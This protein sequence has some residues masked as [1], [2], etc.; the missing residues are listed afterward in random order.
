MKPAVD[1]RERGSGASH[2]DRAFR[3]YD[4]RTDLLD[5]S[6][7]EKQRWFDALVESTYLPVLG[8][9]ESCRVLDVGCNRGYLLRALQN[10]GFE[11]LTGVDLAPRDLDEARKTTGLDT[12]YCEDAVD[13]L[14]RHR[15]EFDAIIFKARAR[16]PP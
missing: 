7:G 8:P 2:V 12:L 3:E 5:A 11:H 10:K 1:S 6:P 14:E 15:G 16:A 9:P 13:F 4:Q